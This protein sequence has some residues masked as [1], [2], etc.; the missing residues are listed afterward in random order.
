M[1]TKKYGSLLIILFTFLSLETIL[2]QT[3]NSQLTPSNKIQFG[4]NYN[5]PFYS[6]NSLSFSSN[7]YQISVNIP[8]SSKFNIIGNIPHINISYE[9]NFNNV[10]NKYNDNGFGNIFIGLETNPEI[11][12]DRRSILSFGIFLPTSEENVGFNGSYVN[13][14]DL[15][16][17]IPNSL[18]LYFNYAFHKINSH[19]L[20]YGLEIG[21]NILIP[22]KKN[23]G[24]T[25]V[26]L[27]YGVNVGFQINKLSLNAELLGIAIITEKVDKFDDRLINLL[28]F[29]AEWKGTTITP[30]V[31]YK[32][33]LKEDIR[34]FIDGVLGLGVS[35]SLH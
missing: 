14:Y 31:F 23:G 6:N 28:N 33:Y 1:C 5:K 24:D 4:L 29:G 15:Q 25:E 10:N 30:K 16:R 19:G 8:V 27:H 18:G 22:T 21:P 32:I 13:N 2:S 26:L 17:Y 20:F 12:N 35:V 34:D 9:T 3:L 7:V 11:L